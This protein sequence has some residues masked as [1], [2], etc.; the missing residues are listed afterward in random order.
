[1]YG[2][3][4]RP[5]LGRRH[6]RQQQKSRRCLVEVKVAICPAPLPPLNALRKRKLD[7][8]SGRICPA[9]HLPLSILTQFSLLA[10]FFFPPPK[11][12]RTLAP[13]IVR[14]HRPRG[15]ISST[16]FGFLLSHTHTLPCEILLSTTEHLSF[17]PQPTPPLFA[18]D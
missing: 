9:A 1:M 17:H 2:G 15:L 12:V 14:Q 18:R 10:W 3:D 11:S 13:L 8:A 6:S 16:S 5:L 7:R 4:D